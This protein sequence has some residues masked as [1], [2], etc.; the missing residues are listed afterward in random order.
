MTVPKFGEWDGSEDLSYSIYF[1][2]ARADKEKFM[3]TV[4]N[5]PMASTLNHASYK[6]PGLM[7]GKGTEHVSHHG[8]TDGGAQVPEQSGQKLSSKYAHRNVNA[9]KAFQS[10]HENHTNSSDGG[11]VF[12]SS[13]PSSWQPVQMTKNR[14]LMTRDMVT[15]AN[16]SH[17]HPH[18][19]GMHGRIQ[20]VPRPMRQTY[21]DYPA[22]TR[23]ARSHGGSETSS[24]ADLPENI[25]V[26]KFGDW[27]ANDIRAG[28]GFS[29]IF[30]KA[31]GEKK[32]NV[33]QKK[34]VG[35]ISPLRPA[36]DLY[37]ESEPRKK[38]GGWFSTL[39]CVDVGK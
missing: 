24:I 7:P 34:T 12:S 28:E 3:P 21:Q 27:D 5:V 23:T 11:H 1:D 16:V 22:A 10:I 13:T 35:Y 32:L 2:K 4:K 18:F 39:C 31:R 33:S 14:D 36:E 30:D 26:P 9:R 25:A 37:K 6:D 19:D 15:H 8:I 17:F 29:V 38:K 20:E